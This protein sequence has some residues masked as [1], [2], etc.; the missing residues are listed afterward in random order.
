MM[1]AYI[2]TEYKFI[3]VN[4]AFAEAW[5]YSPDYFAGKNYFALFPDIDKQNIFTECIRNGSPYFAYAE[6]F[7][8]NP[9]DE[10]NF[11]YMDWSIA[12]T[13]T[14]GMVDGLVLTSVDI[15][16][17]INFEQ[18]AIE[19][20]Q[21]FYD[22]LNH[23]PV[24][25]IITE[26]DGSI[27]FFNREAER[28]YGYHYEEVRGRPI[29]N[30]IPG[31]F[32]EVHHEIRKKYREHP[33][34]HLTEALTD[35]N[36]HR[37]DGSVLPVDIKLG[38]ISWK[39]GVGTIAMIR[40]I[41]EKKKKEEEL[42]QLSM[43]ASK[44]DNAVFIGNHLFHPKWVNNAFEKQTG[45][46]FSDLKGM[47]PS[48]IFSGDGSGAAMIESM[49]NKL[50]IGKYIHEEFVL[51]KKDKSR[52][53]ASLHITPVLNKEE[54]RLEQ[55]IVIINDIT[56]RKMAQRERDELL[57]TLEERV[58]ERTAELRNT[59]T[60]LKEKTKNITD[61][62]K[63]ARYIQEAFTPPILPEKIK[64]VDAFTLNLPSNVLSGDFHWSYYS[65]TN[66]CSYIAL[67]D[68]TGH[69]VPASLMTIL[70]IQLLEQRIIGALEK[71][72]P[73]AILHEIDHA[74]INFLHQKDSTNMV[75]DGM[76]IMLIR[77]DHDANRLIF[78][79]AGRPLYYA[80]KDGFNRY[81][82]PRTSVGG[83][84][85][86]LDKTFD[87]QQLDYSSG[88]RIYS[89]IIN[90]ERNG[91]FPI[92]LAARMVKNTPASAKR[93]FWNQSRTNLLKNTLN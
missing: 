75:K 61:S 8:F 60:Q 23:A 83:S 29:E 7:L 1:V 66:H 76:E 9:L 21:R 56:S 62:I 25:V 70:S 13:R 46:K 40:D 57:R 48:E 55:I 54:Q 37:K 59:Y 45:Y 77:I 91:F 67:G 39:G 81:A 84:I 88:D 71:R 68:C 72:S 32:I 34:V 82:S 52:F 22:A 93:N 4:R 85:A 10:N 69:G 42:Q 79:G 89:A 24:A 14:Y 11:S 64:V 78:S 49:L 12:P 44:V 87:L 16:D 86:G 3:Q 28:Y 30:I 90:E 19:G 2:D 17:R 41:T 27:S 33:E 43:V 53:W 73:D 50:K 51:V 58:N 31:N 5:G 47:T 18:E 26:E 36:S 65:E 74:I 20:R 92:S 35:H 15:T 80:S 6:P 63:Y 38:P